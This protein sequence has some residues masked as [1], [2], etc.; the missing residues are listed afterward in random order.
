MMMGRQPCQNTTETSKS[1]ILS[2]GFPR[3][4][5]GEPA[6]THSHGHWT[7]NFGE[8]HKKTQIWKYVFRVLRSAFCC[9]RSPKLLL[10]SAF[11]CRS[12]TTSNGEKM[13]PSW[14]T[15]LNSARLQALHSRPEAP[16]RLTLHHAFY[17]AVP[18]DPEQDIIKNCSQRDHE[19]IPTTEATKISKRDTKWSPKLPKKGTLVHKKHEKTIKLLIF[20]SLSQNYLRISVV[21]ENDLK[22][23][24][25]P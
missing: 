4:E 25:P 17:D 16:V 10:R 23:L 7:V 3:L 14:A 15:N 2:A 12:P 24:L 20:R 8:I 6:S 19:F 21:F 13:L 9:I 1:L 11:P 5:L 22:K 18:D